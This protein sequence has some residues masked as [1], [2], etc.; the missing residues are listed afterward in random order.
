MQRVIF[1]VLLFIFLFIW[2]WWVIFLI[3]FIGIF[4]FKNFYEFIIVTLIIYSLYSIQGEGI[5]YSSTF[6]S[7]VTIFF[8]FLIQYLKNNIILYKNEIS[9]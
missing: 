7:L 2:P 5:L 3:L 4:I 1:D 8:Y 6:I 9:H